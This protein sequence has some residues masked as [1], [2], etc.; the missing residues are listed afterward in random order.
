MENPAVQTHRWT[1]KL[2]EWLDQAS[3]EARS[4]G[5]VGA[6]AVNTIR[7]AS[8]LVRVLADSSPRDVKTYL[9][10]LVMILDELLAESPS[11]AR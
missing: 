7:D 11:Q 3:L 1:P 10:E 8:V 5:D 9:P 6:A 4:S 2:V